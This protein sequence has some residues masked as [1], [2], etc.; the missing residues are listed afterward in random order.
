MVVGGVRELLV[1]AGF[2]TEDNVVVEVVGE[3]VAVVW[4]VNRMVLV[5]V[6]DTLPW[7]PEFV[8]VVTGYSSSSE[9][10]AV[11]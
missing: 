11:M 7:R 10:K 5:G 1:E 4:F 6:I 3:S 9:S 2:M 8:L